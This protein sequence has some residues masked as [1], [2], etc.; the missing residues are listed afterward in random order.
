MRKYYQSGS[1]LR[2]LAEI[3]APKNKAELQNAILQSWEEIELQFIRVRVAGPGD[4]ML[5]ARNKAVDAIEYCLKNYLSKVV[6][7]IHNMFL[8]KNS[9]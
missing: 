8:K 1:Q 7:C 3:S 6:Y 4:R 9:L 5:Q 2:D